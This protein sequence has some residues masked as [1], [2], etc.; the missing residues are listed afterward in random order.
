MLEAL[1]CGC[2]VLASDTAPVQEF[3]EDGVNGRLFG[4][5]DREAM[6]D[7]ISELL[8]RDTTKMRE[9][10]RRSVEGRLDFQKHI[11]PRIEQMLGLA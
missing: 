9:Q 5:F 6:L 10:A 7:G 3:I 2:A 11:R 8:Q 4:F 1:A